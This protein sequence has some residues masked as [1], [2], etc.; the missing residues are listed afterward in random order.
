MEEE[1]YKSTYRQLAS[2]RC[3][4]EKAITNN[5]ASCPLAV[6]FYLAD[7]EGYACKDA[8]CSGVC[9]EFLQVLREKSQF[10][11]KLH[12]VDGPLPHNREVKIQV[13]G[14]N[15]L[16]RLVDA[17]DRVVNSSNNSTADV[18]NINGVINRAIEKFGS[19]AELPYS[20]IIQSV[21]QF[22]GRRRRQR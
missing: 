2:V 7:R 16:L 21:E 19:L 18:A 13:G 8:V 3:V 11:F 17:D 22:Q 9:S 6:H 12:D 20:E 15:G 5:H 14:I 1:A 10:V 4:F